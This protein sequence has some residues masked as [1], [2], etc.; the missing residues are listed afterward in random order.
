MNRVQAIDRK[1][2][3]D[4]DKRLSILSQRDLLIRKGTEHKFY[5]YD[6]KAQKVIS[7]GYKN[8]GSAIRKAE[9]ID[10]ERYYATA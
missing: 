1:Y 10:D 7:K 3:Y 4:R 2:F 8:Y 6:S 5:I 9:L